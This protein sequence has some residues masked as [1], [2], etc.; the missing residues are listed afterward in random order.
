MQVELLRAKAPVKQVWRVTLGLLLALSMGALT[1]CGGNEGE[2]VTDDLAT[3]GLNDEGLDSRA[4]AAATFGGTVNNIQQGGEQLTNTASVQQGGEVYDLGLFAG[5][6]LVDKGIFALN[7]VDAL[8]GV[9]LREAIETNVL[10]LAV[11]DELYIFGILSTFEDGPEAMCAWWQKE[12]PGDSWTYE[13]EEDSGYFDLLLSANGTP[14]REFFGWWDEPGQYLWCQYNTPESSFEIDVVR[15]SFGWALQTYDPYAQ[16]V[17]RA[18]FCD[19]GSPDGGIGRGIGFYAQP[20]ALESGEKIDLPSQWPDLGDNPQATWMTVD[21]DLLNVKAPVALTDGGNSTG[22]QTFS[23][24]FNAADTDTGSSP[25]SSTLSAEAQPYARL[26]HGNP[27]LGA[28]WSERFALSDNGT[29]IWC[30]NEM[31]GASRLRYLAGYWDVENGTLLLDCLYAIVWEDGK[32]V[33][34]NGQYGSYGSATVITDPTTVLYGIDETL[35]LSVGSISH[36]NARD[37]D[38]ATF[39]QLQCWDHSAQ[40]DG[41]LDA[42]WAALETAEVRDTDAVDKNASTGSRSLTGL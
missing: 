18:T 1:A 7:L 15:T 4:S 22:V 34:N 38:T 28:G 24:P 32:E 11:L 20:R 31:D 12:H 33:Q 17:Y 5:S 37:L 14:A 36:D 19:T 41:A 25:N 8:D 27:V 16:T 26:W 21:G 40:T 29:F 42:F 9:N 3:S 2:A 13:Y 23:I 35:E 10:S 6:F 39:N 30:A